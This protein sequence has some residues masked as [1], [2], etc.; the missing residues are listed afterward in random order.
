[1]L[2]YEENCDA[3]YKYRMFV[4]MAGCCHTGESNGSS[5]VKYDA[6]VFLNKFSCGY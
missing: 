4:R 6:Y 2:V 5:Q 1:M 3:K